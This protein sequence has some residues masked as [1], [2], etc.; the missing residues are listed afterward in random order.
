MIYLVLDVVIK[1]NFY[2]IIVSYFLCT[3]FTFMVFIHK[4][5]YVKISTLFATCVLLRE[6]SL[7]ILGKWKGGVALEKTCIIVY[8]VAH[9]ELFSLLDNAPN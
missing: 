1:F 2:S 3:N 8:A 5:V 9:S 6:I 4:V 7:M